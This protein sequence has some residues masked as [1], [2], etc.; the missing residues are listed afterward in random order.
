[1]KREQLYIGQKV[2]ISGGDSFEG[3]NI[4]RE[5]SVAFIERS[6]YRGALAVQVDFGDDG[7]LDWGRYEDLKPAYGDTLASEMTNGAIR[8]KIAKIEEL[9]NE[10]K[11][12]VK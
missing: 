5:C 6:G 7:E 4:G 2:I 11:E 9:L 10:L 1:M 12:I 3:S 8:K